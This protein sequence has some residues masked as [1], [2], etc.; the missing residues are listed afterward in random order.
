MHCKANPKPV[1]KATYCTKKGLPPQGSPFLK[2]LIITSNLFDHN[3]LIC[4]VQ[5]CF[6]GHIS[7]SCHIEIYTACDSFAILI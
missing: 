2:V 1:M 6:A 5:N 3:H 4:L 7:D